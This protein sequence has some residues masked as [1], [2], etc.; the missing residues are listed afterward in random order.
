MVGVINPNNTQ[1]LAE[2]VKAAVKADYQVAPGDPVPNEASSTSISTPTASSRSDLATA[3]EQSATLST[4]AIA[5]ITVGGIL[6]LVLCAG[7][8]FCLIRNWPSPERRTVVERPIVT[9]QVPSYFS[10]DTRQPPWSPISPMDPVGYTSLSPAQSNQMRVSG[11]L[12][13]LAGSGK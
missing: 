6:F 2:Q 11:P 12:A 3:K 10:G 9:G 8:L 7:V 13:E 5:G 4:G 1:T